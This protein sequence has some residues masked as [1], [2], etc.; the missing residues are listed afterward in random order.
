[1][2][3]MMF[4]NIYT[5]TVFVSKSPI[6]SKCGLQTRPGCMRLVEFMLGFVARLSRFHMEHTPHYFTRYFNKFQSL[7]FIY[8]LKGFPRWW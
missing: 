2:V 8:A 7:L 4:N 3:V 5:T 1:M 6:A